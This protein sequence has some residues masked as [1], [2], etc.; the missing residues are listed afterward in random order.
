MRII[1]V[2]YTQPYTS[3]QRK[4]TLELGSALNSPSGSMPSSATRLHFV[5]YKPIYLE[6]VLLLVV[7]QLEF[8]PFLHNLVLSIVP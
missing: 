7:S 1:N 2:I 4:L 8:F 6:Y 3:L 5:H